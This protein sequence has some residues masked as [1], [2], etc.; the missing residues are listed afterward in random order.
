[1]FLWNIAQN[2]Y[3]I[4]LITFLYYY[5]HVAKKKKKEKKKKPPENG[6]YIQPKSRK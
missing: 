6:T 3:N 5:T 1:M 4:F 2:D